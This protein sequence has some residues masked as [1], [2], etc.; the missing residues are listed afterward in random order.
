MPLESLHSLVETLKKRIQDHGAALRA[1]EA[2]T[3]YALIDPLLRELGWDTADPS[4]VMPE[5]KLGNTNVRADYALLRNG[6]PEDPV[7]IVEAKSLNS[8]LSTAAQQSIN[9]AMQTKT[10]YFAVTDGQCWEIYDL[11][12][13][14]AIGEKR[15]IEF[16]MGNQ[17]AAEICL[18]ALALWQPS[19]ETGSAV[20][21]HAPLIQSEPKP[22]VP[23]A[24]PP[25]SEEDVWHPLSQLKPS[26]GNSPPIEIQLPDN[27]IRSIRYWNSVVVEVTQW[28]LN[29]SHLH[30]GLC[31]IPQANSRARYLVHKDPKHPT[32]KGFYNREQVETV[33]VEKDYIIP[34]LIKNTR[35]I[36]NHAGQDPAQ[37]KVRFD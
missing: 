3:R 36:I 16:D 25:T 19:L 31:P 27:S 28:L 2:L 33:W 5:L 12:K 34:E 20:A 11:Y 8:D 15:V 21:G 30:V 14:A 37:F 32:G 22:I 23:R 24:K 6:N 18:Q 7:M 26:Q 13:R 17:P 29:N 10:E 4:L 35:T 1:S 9:Y